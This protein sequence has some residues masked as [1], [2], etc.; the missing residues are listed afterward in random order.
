MLISKMLYD[1]PISIFNSKIFLGVI[2]RTS[3]KGGVEGEG[4]GE[5]RL[6][7]IHI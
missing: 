6:S 1:S 5:E 2:P 7:L 3:V 4:V